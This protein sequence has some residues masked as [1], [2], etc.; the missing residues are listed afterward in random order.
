MRIFLKHAVLAIMIAVSGV[1]VMAVPAHAG[2]FGESDEEKAAREQGGAFQTGLIYVSDHG[3]SLGESGLYL[4]GLPYAMAP[5]QQTHVPLV[6][7][8]S[9]ALQQR[10]GVGGKCLRAQADRP[11]S[12]DHLFHSVLGLMDVQTK[13]HDLALDMLAPCATAYARLDPLTPKGAN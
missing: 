11:I 7:W 12:H 6:V 8:L 10:S 13:A 3:E 9:P 2:L 5:Q 4:H 1:G